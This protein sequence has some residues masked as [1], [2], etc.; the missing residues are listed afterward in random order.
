ML[1]E[2]VASNFYYHAN[3][4]QLLYLIL[5][6]IKILPCHSKFTNTHHLKYYISENP[7]KQSKERK[8]K[9]VVKRNSNESQIFRWYA[10]QKCNHVC[11]TLVVALIF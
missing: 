8:F 1:I 5:L 10:A 9:H 2:N 11:V 3:Y 7:R 4:K 6:R